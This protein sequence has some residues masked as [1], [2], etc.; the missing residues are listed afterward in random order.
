MPGSVLAACGGDTEV[1]Q[2]LSYSEEGHCFLS[3]TKHTVIP[4]TS[5]KHP[6]CVPSPGLTDKWNIT[7]FLMELPVWK[8]GPRPPIDV[9][10]KMQKLL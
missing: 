3:A 10:V 7:L 9:M 4:E 8:E 2:T 5:P 1:N 6:H